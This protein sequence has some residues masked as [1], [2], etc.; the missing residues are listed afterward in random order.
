MRIVAA[1]DVA[2]EDEARIVVRVAARIKR[3]TRFFP[4]R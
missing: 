3:A 1:F 2:E 4:T